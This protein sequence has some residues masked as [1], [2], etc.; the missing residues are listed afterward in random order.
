[1]DNKD[2]P[3]E[4]QPLKPSD[5]DVEAGDEIA[6]EKAILAA[7][8]QEKK[9][10]ASKLLDHPKARLY[11]SIAGGVIL[12]L[13]LVVLGAIAFI[14]FNRGVSLSFHCHPK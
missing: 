6:N 8:D 12:L 5:N 2:Q 1:M 11:L 9:K 14:I 7:E 4:D 10:S 13:L 3:D